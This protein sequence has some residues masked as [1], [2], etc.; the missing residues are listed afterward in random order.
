[1]TIPPN[2]TQVRPR[3]PAPPA[4]GARTRG[5]VLAD[6][7]VAQYVTDL[8]ATHRARRPAGAGPAAV[9]GRER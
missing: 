5:R 9:R 7:V 2:T 4:P 3:R 6:V 1:M 8:S